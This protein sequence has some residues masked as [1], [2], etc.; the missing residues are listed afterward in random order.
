MYEITDRNVSVCIYRFI[1]DLFLYN[2]FL[3]F[4]SVQGL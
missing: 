4:D 1:Q 2:I 3:W